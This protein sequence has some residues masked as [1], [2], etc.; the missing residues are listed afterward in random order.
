MEDLIVVAVPVNVSIC[1][2]YKLVEE[3]KFGWFWE[4]AREKNTE[5]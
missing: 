3:K 4:L 5:K 2:E 1:S